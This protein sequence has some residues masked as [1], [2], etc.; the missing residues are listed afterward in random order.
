MDNLK[1]SMRQKIS[2]AARAAA[3]AGTILR[4]TILSD[5]MLQ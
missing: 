4:N 3:E 5:I 1:N 2:V